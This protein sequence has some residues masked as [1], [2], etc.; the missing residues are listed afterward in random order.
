L[1]IFITYKEKNHKVRKNNRGTTKRIS[2]RQIKQLTQTN[3]ANND[4]DTWIDDKKGID[5]E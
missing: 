4:Y 5:F 2:Q 1:F 3:E